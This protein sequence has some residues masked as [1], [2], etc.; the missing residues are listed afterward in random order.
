MSTYLQALVSAD[1]VVDAMSEDGG[2][3]LEVWRE[4][5][6]KLHMGALM[7]DAIDLIGVNFTPVEKINFASSLKLMAE[8]IT[9]N[10]E[11]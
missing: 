9:R 2:F 6:E 10:I 4:I 3:A 11:D 8:A 1:D 5:A 7:D